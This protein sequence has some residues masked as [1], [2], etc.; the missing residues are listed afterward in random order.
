MS[1]KTPNDSLADDMPFV[2]RNIV[3][4]PV[5]IVVLLGFL[6]L[7]MYKSIFVMVLPG[8]IGVLYDPF[9]GG[10][11]TLKVYS[12]GLM[13]KF[14]WSR[15]YTYDT[16]LQ[17]SKHTIQALSSEGMSVAVELT[18]LFRPRPGNTGQLHQELGPLYKERVIGP[19]VISAVREMI[20]RHRSHEFYTTAFDALQD[21]IEAELLNNPVSELVEFRSVLISDIT[22]PS[23]VLRA[24]E[25]KLEQEQIAD[26]YEFTLDSQR[27]E[28]ER[29][30]IEAIGL[31]N[32]YAIVGSSLTPAL[33]SWRGIEATVELSRSPNSKI[34]VIGNG[35]DQLPIILG[36]DT[37]QT[38]PAAPPQTIDPISP[39][40][41]PLEG[42]LNL[43]RLFPPQTHAITTNPVPGPSV[44]GAETLPPSNL[45]GAGTTPPAAP[46][47]PET[48][49]ETGGDDAQTGR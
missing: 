23:A 5:A 22:L 10:T 15:F 17:P 30:R 27:A 25:Y 3:V 8:E 6:T 16:R 13:V 47:T 20:S 1:Q 24:I 9:R 34:V 29:L 19:I 37:T 49:S 31:Q 18:V 45:P 7:A 40:A 39:D 11:Q 38:D 41:F 26:A 43:P 32:F 4:Y 48:S 14:P 44:S 12:E 28:A 35:G 21:E 42:R 36:S 2:R 33:L 46:E